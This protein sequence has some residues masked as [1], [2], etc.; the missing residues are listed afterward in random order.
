MATTE[1]IDLSFLDHL[2]DEELQELLE[3]QEELEVRLAEEGPQTDDELHAWIKQELG[4]DIPRTAVCEDHDA[5]FTF[6]ADL[7][8]ERTDAALLMANRGGSKTFLVALLHWLNSRFK[9][10]CESCTFGATEAQS[11][12]AYAHLKGWIFDKEATE[13]RGKAVLRPEIAASIM[14]ET[15]WRNGSKVEVLPGTPAAVNGPHPQ[16]AHADEIE[17]M[18]ASTWKESRNMTVSKT[19]KLGVDDEGNDI[20]R[21][22]KPQD[23]ATSTRKGPNGRMQEL[24]DE[25]GDAIRQGMKPPRQLYQ[26]CIKETAQERPDCQKA[27]KM[28][29]EIRLKTLGRDPCELCDCHEIMKGEWEPGKPRLLSDICNGDFFKSRG[30]Q[31]P[32]E[33]IKQFRENDQETFEV[34]QLCAKPEMSHHY[35]PNFSQERH[36]LKDWL[37]DP[38][39]GPIFLSV[40]W[41]GTNPHAVNWYQL[42]A[43][44]VEAVDFFG[45]PT[46]LKEGCVVCF[47]EIYI[48]EIGNEKLA[49]LVVAKE[50]AW[51]EK[52]PG[53]KVYERFAD[54]QGKAARTDW[55]DHEPP[56]ITKWHTTRE[57]DEHVKA[58]KNQFE[59]D[60]F[61]VVPSR[62]PMWVAEAKAWRRKEDS[63]DQLDE[64][65]H[66]MSNFR[67]AIANIKKIRRRALRRRS[68]PTARTIRRRTVVISVRKPDQGPIAL[69]TRDQMSEWRRRLGSPLTREDD[70]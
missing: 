50:A 68:L 55:R 51:R 47:D 33:V 57:F 18:D 36:G 28:A 1:P 37:P 48:A 15:T 43:V 31:P 12:R 30:W 52:I 64:F 69:R 17:L 39:N 25:I 2:S 53:F 27:P 8:F 42:L 67:Y 9:P 29:R 14:R 24:I 62:C 40:D 20:I 13:S 19:V 11:L 58:V 4:I 16:K 44:E 5:P 54:P 7:Y 61:R 45:R 70:R 32:M 21:V 63:D 38:A 6:I 10:G 26:W 66:C 22:I 59:D 60:L 49:D 34:Q 46:R 65:N 41:G 23:I 3:A 35:L 56:L